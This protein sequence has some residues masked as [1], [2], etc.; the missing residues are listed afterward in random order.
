MGRPEHPVGVGPTTSVIAG[1]ARARRSLGCLTGGRYLR[2]AAAAC[3]LALALAV[4][5]CG[6]ARRQS[7]QQQVAQVLRSYL[8]A[9]AA[10]DG[11]SACALLTAS[12]Q[13]QLIALVVNAGQGLITTRPSCQDAVGLV[14]AVA[15]SRLLNALRSAQIENV[16]VR[17]AQASA[18]VVV[19]MQ[20]A[21]RVSLEKTGTAWKIAGVPGLSG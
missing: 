18:V 12:G 3:L 8:R 13:S 16:Q 6:A 5:G 21:Q 17:G 1:G 9:Q 19:D 2:A 4:A 15:G 10:G 14:S 20:P 11:Q 7:G